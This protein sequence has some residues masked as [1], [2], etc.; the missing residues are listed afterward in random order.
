[1]IHTQINCWLLLVA[2]LEVLLCQS[3]A[4]GKQPDTLRPT[5]P[6]HFFP[7]STPKNPTTV[8]TIPPI[9]SHIALLVGEPV[10]NRETSEL[11]DLEAFS[12]QIIR[13]IPTTS[14]TMEIRLFISVYW[15][16]TMVHDP[17]P[18]GLCSHIQVSCPPL[19]KYQ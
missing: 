5:N 14:N 11:N 6:H 3:A 7:P 17:Q 10:K 1:M 15:A 13:T 12:P 19:V 2:S 18:L 9:K 4:A 8:A 16:A